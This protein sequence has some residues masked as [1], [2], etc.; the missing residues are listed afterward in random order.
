[1][2]YFYDAFLSRGGSRLSKLR[3]ATPPLSP[4]YHTLPATQEGFSRCIRKLGIHLLHK[5]FDFSQ[6]KCEIPAAGA[7]RLDAGE[8][9]MT[10]RQKLVLAALAAGTSS[11]E[12]T[13]VQAQKLLFLIDKN[14]ASTVGGP[15]FRFE[16]YDYGPFDSAVYSDLDLLSFAP[17]PYVEVV[18]SGRYR[19]YRLTPLGRTVGE[20]SLRSIEPAAR[21]YIGRAKDWVKG[22]SF[23]ALVRAIY[24]AYPEMRANSIFRG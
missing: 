11:S 1:M 7:R 19:T 14:V 3:V 22:L 9:L 5:M 8:E 13:P 17:S 10:P 16:P 15:H 12:V 20:E 4:D 21:D 6:G 18:R 23:Q 24:D 2:Q